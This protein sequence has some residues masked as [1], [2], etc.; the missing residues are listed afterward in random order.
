[1]ASSRRDTELAARTRAVLEAA[2]GHVFGTEPGRLAAELYDVLAR[3]TD[4]ADRARVA[5]ALA[6]CWVYG[7]HA[8][9]AAPFADEALA[10]AEQAGD[11]EL[12]ANCLDAVLAAHWGP[13]ELPLRQVTASRLDEVSAHVLDPDARLRG[14][15]WGLQVGWETLRLPTIQRQL[16]ALELLAGESPRARF[17]AASRRWMYEHVRGLEAREFIEVAEDAAAE[18]GLADAWMVT[19]LMRGYTA[20]RTGDEATA[21]EMAERMEKFAHDEGVTEVATEAASVWALS[22]HPDRARALLDQ[23]GPDVLET[24][25]R[26]VNFLL[27]LHCVLEAALAVGDEDIV[28]TAVRLLTP[29]ENRA[30]VNSGAV[31]F[32]GVTDDTLARAAALTGDTERA[33]QLRSRAMST[34]LKLGATWWHERLSV[35]PASVV[36]HFHPADDGLWL[37]GSA[38]RPMRALRGFGYLHRLLEQPGRTVS[39]IDLVTG[40]VATVIQ[41]DAGPNLDHR[42]ATAYRQRLNDLA[43]ELDEA[44]DWSDLARVESLTAERDALLAEL[45]SAAGL[46]G[47][48]RATGSTAERARVAA[49]KAITTA[50][51][52]IEAVDP[53]LATHL[54]DAIRTGTDCSY[55]PRPDEHRAWLLSG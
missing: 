5:A 47:R 19:G 27:N 49:T 8:D 30:V 50:I 1:M 15:L 38:A 10:H 11:P 51:T 44:T 53:D 24:M 37:V 23:L 41:S 39:A 31:Y 26:D 25:P 42:A 28:R 4:D 20:L 22:G 17:F 18:A 6:R 43:A 12:I 9:R 52:H 32:H 48:S 55:R 45:S 35:D 46:G 36:V 14:H 13:D 33:E 54:R 40:G 2:S 3:T 21:T 7:G 29:Y 34:Y 16:R